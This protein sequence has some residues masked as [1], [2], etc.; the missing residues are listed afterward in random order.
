MSHKQNAPDILD[1]PDSTKAIGADFK[2]SNGARVLAA[3]NAWN[4]SGS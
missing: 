2:R 1:L 4:S 3:V